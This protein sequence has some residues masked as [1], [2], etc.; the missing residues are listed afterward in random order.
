MMRR[1]DVYA[2]TRKQTLSVRDRRTDSETYGQVIAH[3]SSVR[4]HDTNVVTY[5]DKRRKA[6]RTG[7]KNVHA[8]FR[9]DVLVIDKLTGFGEPIEYTVDREG[10]FYADG[11]R[12]LGADVVEVS[13]D[14]TIRAVGI[15]T[16]ST[17][18]QTERILA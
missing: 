7:R 17:D 18:R 14:G 3:P 10:C 2:H 11:E 16:E 4:I 12:V 8:M 13:A 6:A 1:A 5:E 9:G 15:E